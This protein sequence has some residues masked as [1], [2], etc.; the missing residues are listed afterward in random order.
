MNLADRL[1]K[2]EALEAELPRKAAPIIQPGTGM[3]FVDWYV[4]GATQRTMA[5]SRGCRTMIETRNFPG[6]AILMGRHQW[7][8][9]PPA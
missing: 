1:T 6:A 8:P 7:A 5:Q 4:M 2:I 3:Y 9:S